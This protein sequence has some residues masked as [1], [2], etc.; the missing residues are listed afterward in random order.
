[1][2]LHRKFDSATFL[3]PLRRR[4]ACLVATGLS[5]GHKRPLLQAREWCP[6]HPHNTAA[7][8]ARHQSP[9]PCPVCPA[10]WPPRECPNARVTGASHPFHAIHMNAV[11]HHQALSESSRQSCLIGLWVSLLQLSISQVPCSRTVLCSQHDLCDGRRKCIMLS[12][13]DVWSGVVNSQAASTA[14]P[15]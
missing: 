15:H 4:G 3:R 13:T 14:T 9:E 11:P 8:L 5:L 2:Q 10:C 6:T 1:M 12:A 7:D